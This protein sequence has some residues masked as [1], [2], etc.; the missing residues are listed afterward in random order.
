MT[1]IDMT[2]EISNPYTENITLDRIEY[3]I[4]VNEEKIEERITKFRDILMKG[5]EVIQAGEIKTIEVLPSGIDFSKINQKTKNLILENAVKW[6]VTGTVYF[7]TSKGILSAPIQGIRKDYP[8]PNPSKRFGTVIYV[9]DK[10]WNPIAQAKVSLISKLYILN[11][12]TDEEGKAIFLNLPYTNYTLTLK[13]S[14][15]GY[16]PYEKSIEVSEPFLPLGETVELYPIIELTIEVRDIAGIPINNANVTLSSKDVGD[17]IK[18]T[19]AS[20]VAEFKIPRTDYTLTVSKKGYLPHEESL[21]LSKSKIES[22]VIQLKAEIPWWQQHWY[23]I[24][25]IVAICVIVP[26]IFKIKRKA[27]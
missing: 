11:K 22:K 21:D 8:P 3:Q 7:A 16:F 25:G 9:K 6:D 18:N 4:Y 26:V 15:E 5:E 23:V 27:S 20:G 12:F 13:V 17:F 10:D 1:S 2:F 14:K 19:N 24:A